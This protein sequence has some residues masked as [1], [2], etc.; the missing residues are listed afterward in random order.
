M[1][2]T[3]WKL[4]VTV[5]NCCFLE[6][7]HR[8]VCVC[9]LAV[10]YTDLLSSFFCSLFCVSVSVF[11]VF[12][13]HCINALVHSIILF[14]FPLKMLEHGKSRASEANQFFFAIFVRTCDVCSLTDS[15][16]SDGLGNDYLFVGNMVYTVRDY[17][18]S[19]IYALFCVLPC[20]VLGDFSMPTA[21]L[22]PSV[23]LVSSSH[24]V[25][26]PHLSTSC[27]PSNFYYQFTS[28][29]LE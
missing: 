10:A 27:L 5:R 12:W 7:G 21:A 29:S 1:A 9:V 14:W 16:F 22:T 3:Q 6:G 2:G 28:H 23:N 20:R 4:Y 25:S 8:H 11:Q 13:G 26:S 18:F 15:P 19:H 17:S 24:S